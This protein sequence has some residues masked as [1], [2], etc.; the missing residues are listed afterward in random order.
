MKILRVS[1]SL[2]TFALCHP[3][4]EKGNKSEFYERLPFGTEALYIRRRRG[5][6]KP[7]SVAKI[8]WFVFV[9]Q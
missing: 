4:G 6:S 3:H 7:L 5:H 9:E 8:P 2:L 1:I